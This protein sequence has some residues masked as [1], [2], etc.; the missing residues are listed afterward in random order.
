MREEKRKE[1]QS[2]RSSFSL[3]GGHRCESRYETNGGTPSMIKCLGS[4]SRWFLMFII[5]DSSS[6]FLV[7]CHHLLISPFT[8]SPLMFRGGN[9]WALAP[10]LPLKP[11]LYSTALSAETRVCNVK[12]RLSLKPSTVA[13]PSFTAVWVN[14][15]SLEKKSW[16][17]MASVVRW[18]LLLLVV[19]EYWAASKWW[20]S[21]IICFN[22]RDLSL[23]CFCLFCL[24]WRLHLSL[25]WEIKI[26]LKSGDLASIPKRAIH[27]FFFNKATVKSTIS[28]LNFYYKW[29]ICAHC[30]L[31]F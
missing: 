6:W 29:F 14:I 23:V 28:I 30:H 9:D 1:E 11:V 3:N 24:F 19:S 17:L 2:A 18:L 27:C 13:F 31:F 22:V 21:F 26:A 5:W 4:S 20:F 16:G 8:F 12:I 25:Y 10:S 7:F 15:W